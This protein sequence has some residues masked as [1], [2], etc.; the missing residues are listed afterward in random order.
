M[1]L[2]KGVPV[3]PKHD[4]AVTRLYNARIGTFRA[5]F[6]RPITAEKEKH[7]W[8]CGPIIFG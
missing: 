1:R 5:Q 3:L 7:L 2:P 6:D 8:Q 4:K